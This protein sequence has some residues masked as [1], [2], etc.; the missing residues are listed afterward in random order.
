MKTLDEQLAMRDHNMKEYEGETMCDYET[1]KYNH[2]NDTSVWFID[3]KGNEP[4]WAVNIQP[5]YE[6]EKQNE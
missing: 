3:I 5:H 4:N 1:V 6:E 2:P